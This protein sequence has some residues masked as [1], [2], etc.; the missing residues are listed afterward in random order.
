MTWWNASVVKI[1]FH[2]GL[3][4]EY[5]V[6]SLQLLFDYCSTQDLL[7]KLVSHTQ[8]PESKIVYHK[9]EGDYYRYLAEMASSRE[10]GDVVN[11]CEA[12]YKAAISAAEW[13][14]AATHPVRLGI[15]LN[16]SVFYYEIYNSSERACQVAQK[17]FHTAILS[18]NDAPEENLWKI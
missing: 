3:L 12:A 17:V 9:M 8:D 2:E 18:V 14:M 16:F 11:K 13:N 6:W 15:V 5:H 10:K 4:G 1:L 7:E